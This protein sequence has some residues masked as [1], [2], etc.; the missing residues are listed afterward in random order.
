MT[1]PIALSEDLV[2]KWIKE[3]HKFHK[4][5]L[6]EY[7]GCDCELYIAN[8]AAV[9]A[10]EQIGKALVGM[11]PDGVAGLIRYEQEMFRN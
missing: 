8:Q 1:F 2:K 9:W 6:S 5:Q 7:S 10:A 4:L 3:F 11:G